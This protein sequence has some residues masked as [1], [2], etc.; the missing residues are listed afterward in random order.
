MAL[1]SD[2]YGIIFS[3][4]SY[5]FQIDN[6]KILD[7]SVRI[8]SPNTD[9]KR[10]TGIIYFHGGGFVIGNVENYDSLNQMI[11]KKLKMIC[12]LN[13]LTKF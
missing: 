10:F 11:V 1:V 7:V 13:Q 12:R 8:Y 3:N 4:Y 6:R 2:I 9:L 5:F